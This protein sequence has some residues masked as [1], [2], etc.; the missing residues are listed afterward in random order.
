MTLETIGAVVTLFGAATIAIAGIG[1]LR[2][3]DIY[4]RL[5]AITSAGGLGVSFVVV[6]ALLQTP[7]VPNTV[8][9][10]AAVVLQLATSAVGGMALGRSSYLTGSRLTPATRY[11]DLHE[12]N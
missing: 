3:P 8:K 2:L 5:S 7:S 4:T 6:G 11:D 1:L 10:V 9:V 12:G